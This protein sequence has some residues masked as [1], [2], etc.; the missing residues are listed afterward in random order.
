MK[1]LLIH[2]HEKSFRNNQCGVNTQIHYSD[3]PDHKLDVLLNVAGN[4]LFVQSLLAEFKKMI[5]LSKEAK[6]I[7]KQYIKIMNYINAELHI[8]YR[9]Y[10]SQRAQT[11]YAEYM[12]SSE[13]GNFGGIHILH[14]YIPQRKPIHY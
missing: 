5:Q 4:V 8:D 9:E 2:S 10:Y 11:M 6:K 1:K 12:R 14:R 7:K 13:N 3:N